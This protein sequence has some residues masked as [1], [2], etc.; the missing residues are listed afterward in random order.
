MIILFPAIVLQ[1]Q[2]NLAQQKNPE[3]NIKLGLFES[4]PFPDNSFDVVTSKWAFQTSAQIDPIY[5]EIARVLKPNGQLI[6]LSSH[7]IRQFIEKKH[8]GKDYHA[9]GYAESNVFSYQDK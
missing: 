5:H 6:Y 4:I 3:G 1:S 8:K 9:D 7:P 2:H